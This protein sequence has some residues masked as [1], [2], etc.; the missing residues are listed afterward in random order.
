M[1]SDELISCSQLLVR[2]SAAGFPNLICGIELDLPV[3]ERNFNVKTAAKVALRP[4]L[5]F[6][7]IPIDIEYAE[8]F[9]EALFGPLR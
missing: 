6:H 2:R 1:L 9:L 3:D 5:V 7:N 4:Q 8:A